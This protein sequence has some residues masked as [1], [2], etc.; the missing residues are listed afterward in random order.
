MMEFERKS[1]EEVVQL[2]QR[3]AFNGDIRHV[4]ADAAL[5]N[6]VSS[7]NSIICEISIDC[8]GSI[9]ILRLLKL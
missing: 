9:H 6:L 7:K 8:V 5:H 3:Y 4:E 1:C 2:L